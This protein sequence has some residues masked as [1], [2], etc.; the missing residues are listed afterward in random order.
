MVS[1]SEVCISALRRRR[2]HLRRVICAQIAL[3]HSID[4]MWPVLVRYLC[5][6]G[7]IRRSLQRPERVSAVAFNLNVFSQQE[8][9]I[10]YRFFVPNLGRL[11]S[12][13][14]LQVDVSRRRYNV[15]PIECL[16]IVLRRL[17]SPGRWTDLELLFGPS[18]SSLREIFCRGVDEL[19]G[20]WGHLITTRRTALMAERAAAYAATI[21]G[22]DAMLQKCVGFFDGTL[23]RIARPG[24]GLQR[25]CYSGHKRCHAIK[26]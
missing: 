1:Q 11:S 16:D 19:I 10:N 2:S 17:T 25:V 15:S 6:G 23:I 12:L 9:L 18:A 7:Y 13:L 20:R 21:A 22:K 4:E 8:A 14:D 24:H 3:D 26:F 5:V